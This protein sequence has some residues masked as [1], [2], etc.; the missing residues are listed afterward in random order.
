LLLQNP[1]FLLSFEGDIY[2]ERVRERQ[3]IKISISGV[4]EGRSPSLIT[5]PFP[6]I[7]GRGI[8]GDGVTLKIQ[9]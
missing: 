4:S 1:Y 5:S 7:R 9:G 2:L 8:K 3:S 6:L